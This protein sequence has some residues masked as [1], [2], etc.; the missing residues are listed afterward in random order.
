MIVTVIH[1]VVPKG[2]KDVY[3]PLG[4][5]LLA[6]FKLYSTRRALYRQIPHLQIPLPHK[7]HSSFRRCDQQDLAG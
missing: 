3:R 4:T 5:T 2:L 1:L 6:R 7:H